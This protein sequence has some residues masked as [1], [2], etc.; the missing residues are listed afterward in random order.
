MRTSDLEL[1]S[2]AREVEAEH[3]GLHREDE[4]VKT[5]ERTRIKVLVEQLH[6]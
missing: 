1:L 4:K 5:M 6:V 3:G 2:R